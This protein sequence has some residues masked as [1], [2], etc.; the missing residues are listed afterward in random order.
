VQIYVPI[1]APQLLGEDL[2]IGGNTRNSAQ[3]HTR[4]L[5]TPLDVL[6]RAATTTG[7]EPKLLCYRVRRGTGQAVDSKLHSC[8]CFIRCCI[9]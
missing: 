5:E 7:L 3:R 6:C 8:S 1:T 4:E 9:H 2:G